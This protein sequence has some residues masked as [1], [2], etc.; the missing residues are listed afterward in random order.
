[1][2]TFKIAR[3]PLLRSIRKRIVSLLD[4]AKLLPNLAEIERARTL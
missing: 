3:L 4:E 1:V 2:A